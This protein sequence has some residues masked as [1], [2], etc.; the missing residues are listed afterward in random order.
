MPRPAVPRPSRPGVG[1]MTYEGTYSGYGPTRGDSVGQRIQSPY[2][3]KQVTQIAYP[4]REEAKD[5]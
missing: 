2:A 3:F 5:G 1:H 4:K